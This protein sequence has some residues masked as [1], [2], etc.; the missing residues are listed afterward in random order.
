MT[1]KKKIELWQRLAL[2][3]QENGFHHKGDSYLDYCAKAL[4]AKRKKKA[5]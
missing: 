4:R 5:K 3:A 1:T 2:V